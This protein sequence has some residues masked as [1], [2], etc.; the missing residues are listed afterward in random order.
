MTKAMPGAAGDLADKQPDI[1]SAYA[2]FGKACADAGPLSDREN[3]LC[4]WL[5][6]LVRS[7]KAP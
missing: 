5:W 4:S 6:Q 2:D 1:W 3:S 7:P